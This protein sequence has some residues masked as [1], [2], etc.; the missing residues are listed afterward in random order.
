MRS[1]RRVVLDV[2]LLTVILSAIMVGFL[3]AAYGSDSGINPTFEKVDI[4]RI[5][6]DDAEVT[7]WVLYVPGTRKIISYTSDSYSISCLPNS[8]I[9]PKG[10]DK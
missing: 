9:N 7:C 6:D 8:A 5:H 1:Y 2:A 4:Q 10:T 3:S